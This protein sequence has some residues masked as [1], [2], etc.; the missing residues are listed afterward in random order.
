MRVIGIIGDG[1]AYCYECATRA[2]GAIV[3]HDVWHYDAIRHDHEGNN[4]GVIFSDNNDIVSCLSC[5]DNLLEEA[6]YAADPYQ[7]EE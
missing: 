3:T 4:I 6:G 1:T 7:D 2:Y 5:G